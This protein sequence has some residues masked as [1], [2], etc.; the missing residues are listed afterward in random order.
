VTFFG[1]GERGAEEWAP[2][3]SSLTPGVFYSSVILRDL[4]GMQLSY[5]IATGDVPCPPYDLFLTVEQLQ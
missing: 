3:L 4:S 1:T 2:A 5:E